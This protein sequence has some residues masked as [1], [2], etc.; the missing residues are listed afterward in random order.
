MGGLC[1]RLLEHL[2]LR[3][4]W[5]HGRS[6]ADQRLGSAVLWWCVARCRL[7]SLGR[8]TRGSAGLGPSSRRWSGRG[9]GDRRRRR[10]QSGCY[11]PAPARRLLDGA[12][13][14]NVL[15]HRCAPRFRRFRKGGPSCLG[16]LDGGSARD[17]CQGRPILDGLP[18]DARQGRSVDLGVRLT[19]PPGMLARLS[20]CAVTLMLTAKDFSLFRIVA[21]CCSVAHRRQLRGGEE[22]HLPHARNYSGDLSAAVRRRRKPV[23]SSKEEE[24]S[25]ESGLSMSGVPVRVR[26]DRPGW[27][28]TA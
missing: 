6:F 14:G 12:G 22:L 16:R 5:P 20:P 9:G 2:V 23:F 27:S 24:S 18:T 17:V 13:R 21:A 28:I 15:L 10:S 25:K 1:G 19:H 4:R 8:V 11:F 3:C 7:R 26:I